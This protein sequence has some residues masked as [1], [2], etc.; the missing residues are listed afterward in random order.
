M[1]GNATLKDHTAFCEMFV[2]RMA[3][4]GNTVVAVDTETQAVFGGFLNEDYS[5]EVPP[6]MDHFMSTSDGDWL[7]C[8]SMI[9]E[10]EEAFNATYSVPSTSIPSGKWFHLWMIG[11][12]PE[13]R[14]RS[15][16]KKLC[17]HSI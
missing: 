7:P 4:E 1:A 8:V 2:P 17:T 6:G 11:V 12:A 14:G 5:N 13:A 16:G 9:G 10:L 15:I 3:V